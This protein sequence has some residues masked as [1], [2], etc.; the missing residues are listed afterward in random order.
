MSL[1]L[2]YYYL[3]HFSMKQAPYLTLVVA[4]RNDNYGGNFNQRLN[5]CIR[6][7][8]WFA[9]KFKLPSEFLLVYY[10]PVPGEKGL[11]EFLFFPK[12]DFVSFRII[13]VPAAFHEKISDEKI[14]K[15]IPMYEFIAK[16]IG[17][18]RAKGLFVAATTADVRLDPAI[19]SAIAGQQLNFQTY[20][21]GNRA[22]YVQDWDDFN[23]V[24]NL[25]DMRK[26]IFKIFM[27]GFQ[28]KFNKGSFSML[29][30]RALNLFNNLRLRFHLLLVKNQKLANIFSIPVN[31]DYIEFK[32]HTNCCGDFTMMHKQNWQ[33]LKGY[34]QD[35][36]LATHTDALFVAMAYFSGLKEKIFS[37]P[38]YHVDHE[39]RFEEYDTNPHII[40]MYRKFE[41]EG[42]KMER[43]GKAIIYNDENWGYS[44]E[45]FEEETIVS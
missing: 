25:G 36:Y 14:R 2:H 32:A 7:H 3:F 9:D 21:R 31:P 37:H 41:E 30:L 16:N 1:N 45:A 10:N 27:K 44:N 8:T 20:F 5:D 24:V 17:I 15:K 43:Q 29:K 6:W 23:P 19:I 33:L 28:Y 35:T 34:P 4:A 39:R 38:V 22:D 13:T 40:A 12:S 11:K 18:R 42:K 26:S